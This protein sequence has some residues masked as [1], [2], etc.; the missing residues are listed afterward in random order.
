MP[1]KKGE[2]E[3][4][5]TDLQELQ[6]REKQGQNE[7]ALVGE[8][9]FDLE[10]MTQK[11]VKF[12]EAVSGVTFYPYQWKYAEGIIRSLLGNDG[13]EI[14]ALFSRQSGK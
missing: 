3:L 14:T 7:N 5:D 12:C 8:M 9:V 10:D 4:I 6:K 1:K 11:V 13:E 2:R